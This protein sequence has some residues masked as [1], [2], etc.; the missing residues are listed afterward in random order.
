MIFLCSW[1]GCFGFLGFRVLFLALQ[2]TP[3]SFSCL[4]PGPLSRFF[5]PPVANI[6]EASVKANYVDTSCH[7]HPRASMLSQAWDPGTTRILHSHR[8]SPYYFW[9]M[10]LQIWLFD[11]KKSHL[12][13][14]TVSFIR[15]IR[16]SK[17]PWIYPQL[18][19]YIF[20]I[21]FGVTMQY[22]ECFSWERIRYM[23]E[24]G[25]SET[26]LHIYIYIYI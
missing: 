3:T 9:F 6:R 21:V 20:S 25:A 4:F 1:W 10:R 18:F 16:L 19:S 24:A 26:T 7:V 12:T 8:G 22:W 2:G 5:R 17:Y 11:L 13:N 14:H 15:F 23:I